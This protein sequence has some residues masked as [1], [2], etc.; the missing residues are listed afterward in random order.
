MKRIKL[1]RWARDN[2]IHYQTAYRMHKSG[3]L[4]VSVYEA[5]SGRLYV[6]VDDRREESEKKDF[7]L[8]ARVSS[9]D[10]K[11]DLEKQVK[12]LKD[13]ASQRGLIIK[14]EYREIGSGLDGKR[15]KLMKSLEGNNNI[16][17]EHQDRL[18]RFGFDYIESALKSQ[19]REIV[20]I[21]KTEEK[22]DL[23]QDFIDVC[24]SMCSRI[25][26]KRGAKSKALK[27]IESLEEKPIS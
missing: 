4:P 10:Q 6:E 3:T 15:P 9:H 2:D 17:A 23:G 16:L 18:V 20:I 11:E 5:P 24:T 26:G 12:R 19:G 25:Y 13:F 7:D 8:Y 1:S 21:N 27:M 14:N 22:M